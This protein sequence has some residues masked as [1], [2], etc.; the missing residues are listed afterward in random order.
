METPKGKE[1][2]FSRLNHKKIDAMRCNKTN[3]N[4]F[5][6]TEEF[7]EFASVNK[8]ENT[9]FDITFNEFKGTIS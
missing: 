9:C 7:S 3:C 6:G 8:L 1:A 4:S 2:F 5:N